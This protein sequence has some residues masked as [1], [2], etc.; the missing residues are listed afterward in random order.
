MGFFVAVVVVVVVV[1]VFVVVDVVVVGFV[2]VVVVV[3]AVVVVVVVVVAVVVVVVAAVAG[4]F[5]SCSSRSRSGSRV[6]RR[7]VLV[8]ERD[9]ELTLQIRSA[10]ARRSV[11]ATIPIV[12]SVTRCK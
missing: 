6:R 10:P 12:R 7:S 2:V 5:A 9:L 8:P 1:V 11:S 3:A 4:V